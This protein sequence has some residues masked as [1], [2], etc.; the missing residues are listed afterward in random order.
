MFL[1]AQISTP[2]EYAVLIVGMAGPSEN[3]LMKYLATEIIASTHTEIVESDSM[4]IRQVLSI[5][6]MEDAMKEFSPD[7]LTCQE[8]ACVEEVA[9]KLSI[10]RL[11]LIELDQV[12]FSGSEKER[13]KVSGTIKI[14]LINVELIAGTDVIIILTE[15]TVETKLRGTFKELVST[16]RVNTWTLFGSELPKERFSEDEIIGTQTTFSQKIAPYVSDQRFML[17]VAVAA[18]LLIGGAIFV[19]VSSNDVTH[20]YPPDFPEIP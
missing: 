1:K 2:Q 6:D 15:N 9:K 18:G 3:E 16:I 8:T 19:M 10:E 17:T 12:K 4:G 11:I 13:L 14:S 7:G 20:T 5:T